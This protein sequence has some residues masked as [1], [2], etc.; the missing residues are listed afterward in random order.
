MR[1][2]DGN[3]LPDELY[4]GTTCSELPEQLLAANKVKGW[5]NLMEHQ[6][7]LAVVD[8][9]DPDFIM[10]SDHEKRTSYANIVYEAMRT[11]NNETLRMTATRAGLER[12]GDDI[13]ILFV[14]VSKSYA[15]QFGRVIEIDRNAEGLMLAIPDDNSISSQSWILVFE[16]GSIFP[17]FR[18]EK[19]LS[20]M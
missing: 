2:I 14:T 16:A 5:W 3:L 17:G 18:N 9:D 11:S 19:S 6:E 15:E 20:P 13:A 1:D 10:E 12:L 4:H 7:F 8:D